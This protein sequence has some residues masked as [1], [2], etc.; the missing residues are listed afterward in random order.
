MLI[1]IDIGARS[2]DMVLDTGS[3]LSS[4]S[5]D[6]YRILLETAGIGTVAGNGYVLRHPMI[7]G[8]RI[9]DLPVRLSRR[10]TRVGADGVLG[11]DFLG[12]FTEIHVHVP[13][14]RLTLTA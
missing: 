13:T 2:F 9:D 6:M 3:P 7:Q 5:E 14:L 10:V 11:I 1:P 12:R 4:I 8:Q